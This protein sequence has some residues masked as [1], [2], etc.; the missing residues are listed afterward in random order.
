MLVT[1]AL[2][3]LTAL[4]AARRE[5]TKDMIKLPNIKLLTVIVGVA[6]V[7]VGLV[8][9]WGRTG[10]PTE[11]LPSLPKVEVTPALPQPGYARYTLRASLP[12]VEKLPVYQYNPPG[13][14]VVAQFIARWPKVLGFSGEPEEIE[15]ALEGTLLLWSKEGQTLVVNEDASGLS[16]RVDLKADPT[17]LSGS[18]LPSFDAA[19]E[20]VERTLEELGS[21]RGGLGLLKHDP[22][23]NKAL[24]TGV[25]LVQETTLAEAELVE[26]YFT[27]LINDYPVYLEGG[28]EWDPVL[29]WVGRDGK[30]LRL[31]YHPVGTVGEKIADYPLKN[32]EELLEDLDNG[33]GIVVSS[34]F[35]G[36]EEIVS[37]VITKIDLGYLLPQSNTT[38]IQPIFV[39]TGQ[40]QT[41]KGKTGT[42][43]IYLPAAH[44]SP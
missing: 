43:T 37:T 11:P 27:A 29:A 5:G 33:E 19:A 44:Q 2:V 3:D 26:V 22:T 17:T 24:K 12:Q 10:A 40:S 14:G 36:G 8:V 41:A 15:D 28:P 4:A 18:F 25:S 35:S 16:Y 9:L 30:L 31:E 42:I 6:F 1:V 38:A 23:K 39:L 7:G 20:I 34:S 32:Q 21:A 13:E